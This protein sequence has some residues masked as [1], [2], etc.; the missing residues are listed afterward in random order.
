MWVRAL[1]ERVDRWVK[2]VKS[3]RR[4]SP[5][6]RKPAERASSKTASATPM[7]NAASTAATPTARNLASAFEGAGNRGKAVTTESACGTDAGGKSKAAA[8]NASGKSVFYGIGRGFKPGVYTSW[9]EANAQ[10]KHFSG[11]RIK[12][13]R[14]K[15]NAEKYVKEMQAEPQVVW[16]VLKTLRPDGAYES[17]GLTSIYNCFGSTMVKRHSLSAAKRF[18]GKTRIKVYREDAEGPGAGLAGEAASAEASAPAAA[19]AEEKQEQF[20]ACK[21]KGSVSGGHPSGGIPR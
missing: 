10:I 7:W 12:K 3:V 4:V 17:K 15:L 5:A 11:C 16:W 8:K 9:D 13:F 21:G 18:L 19:A 2:S 20:F 6:K 14:S 1:L